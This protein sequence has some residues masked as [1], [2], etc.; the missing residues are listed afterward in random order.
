VWCADIG[1]PLEAFAAI[2]V[3]VPPDLFATGDLRRVR[4]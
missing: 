2:G 3:A 1:V 4:P